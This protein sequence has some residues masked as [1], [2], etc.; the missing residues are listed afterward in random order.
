MTGNGIESWIEK[1][2]ILA[3]GSCANPYEIKIHLKRQN[4]APSLR[5]KKYIIEIECYR[6]DI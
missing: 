1:E 6:D 3:G 5:S 2:G 4:R